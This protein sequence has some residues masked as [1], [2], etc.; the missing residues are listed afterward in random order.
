VNDPTIRI[1]LHV[2]YTAGAS[3]VLHPDREPLPARK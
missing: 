1:G 3:G 2:S